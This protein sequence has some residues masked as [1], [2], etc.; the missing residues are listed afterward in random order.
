MESK[1]NKELDITEIINDFKKLFDIENL[2]D[3]KDDENLFASSFDFWIKKLI[4]KFVLL[5]TSK[6]INGYKLTDDEIKLIMEIKFIFDTVDYF[7]SIIIEKI[8]P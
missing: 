3:L 6:F 1:T 7:M 8:M 4:N 5:D 2:E